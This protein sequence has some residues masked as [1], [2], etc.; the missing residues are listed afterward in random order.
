MKVPLPNIRKFEELKLKPDI[1]DEKPE[2]SID[3]EEKTDFS[4]HSSSVY[5]SPTNIIPEPESTKTP[6][7]PIVESQKIL[8]NKPENQDSTEQIPK[9]SRILSYS[10]NNYPN[11]KSDPLSFQCFIKNEEAKLKAKILKIDPKIIFLQRVLNKHNDLTSWPGF[12][13]IFFAPEGSCFGFT[14]MW[15]PEF[16]SVEKVFKLSFNEVTEIG[17]GALITILR[18]GNKNKICLVN[19]K[20]QGNWVIAE[21]ELFLLLLK[22]NSLVKEADHLAIFGLSPAAQKLLCANGAFSTFHKENQKILPQIKIIEKG[23]SVHYSISNSSTANTFTNFIP[24]K[25]MEFKSFSV[26]HL[27]RLPLQ[28]INKGIKLS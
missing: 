24:M 22:L 3:E 28:F 14:S 13:S 12:Q 27:G 19:T 10:L 21:L 25:Y 11:L 20:I 4:Q 7:N 8:L 2:I 15:K 1:I 26:Y 17:G 5:Q 18:F 23:I 6:T 16:C 9:N